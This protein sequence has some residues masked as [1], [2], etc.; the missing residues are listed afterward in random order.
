VLSAEDL[1]LE[2]VP[3]CT[4]IPSKLETKLASASSAPKS[5]NRS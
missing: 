3:T 5:G 1:A 2:A 4:E